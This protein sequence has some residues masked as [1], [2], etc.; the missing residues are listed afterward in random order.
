MQLS[1]CQKKSSVLYGARGV[2]EADTPT[3]RLSAT[4][5]GLIIDPPSS[6][7]FTP[8]AFPAAILPLY[9]GLGQA[10]NTLACISSG[11]VFWEGH[12][13]QRKPVLLI[14]KVVFQNK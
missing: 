5:S 7:I 4:P 6:L 10:P 8:D 9:P 1:Q 14:P 13:A 2:F 11:V 12:L 3:I